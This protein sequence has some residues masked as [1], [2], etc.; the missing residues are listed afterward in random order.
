MRE[1]ILV[2]TGPLVALIDRRDSFHPWAKEQVA[3]LDP[4]LYT[5]EPVLTEA[6]FLLSHLPNGPQAILDFVQQGL[7]AVELA[8]KDEVA[9]VKKLLMRYGDVPISLAD[10]CMVRLAEV[11]PNGI[12]WTIDSDFRIYRLNGRA[13]I[14]LLIPAER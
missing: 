3:A 7:V 5:C 8:L 13:A 11:N 14:P 6:C 1:K 12:L 2:D 10:A 4:P 9:G